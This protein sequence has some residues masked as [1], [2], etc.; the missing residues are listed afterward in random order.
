MKKS[1]AS[2]FHQ[3]YSKKDRFVIQQ[4]AIFYG[5]GIV[6]FWIPFTH[7]FFTKLTPIALILSVV[8]LYYYN[9]NHLNWK[10]SAYFIFVFLA[11]YVIEVFGV[12]TGVIFGSYH[13]GGGL[14]LKLFETPILIGINWALMVYMSSAVFS[15]KSRNFFFQVIASSL[16]MLIYDFILE[17][18]ASKM[19]MWYWAGNQIPFLNY[20][21]WFVIAILFQAIRYFSKIE[22][23]NKMAMPLFL[24]QM[25]FFLIVQIV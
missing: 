9:E 24:V 4:I 2:S 15:K 7:S 18:S 22:I 14:G 1:L 5:I 17:H 11:S 16:L 10:I 23:A 13:Y 25:I 8:L 6:G 19:D 21:M 20:W 3:K 12:K